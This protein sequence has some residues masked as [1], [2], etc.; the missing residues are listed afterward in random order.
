[1]N[2]SSGYIALVL[3][4]AVALPLPAQTKKTFPDLANEFVYTTLAFSPAAATQNGLHQMNTARGTINLDQMLDDFS[5]GSLREQ[6][7]Y[8]QGF[9]A[10]LKA[11]PKA[12]MDAQTR[13]DLELLQNASSFALFS[14]DKERY[15]SWRPQLYPENLGNSLFSNLSLEYADTATRARDLTIR[16]EGVPRFVDDAVGNLTASNAIYRGVALESIDGVVDLIK[17]MGADFVKGTPSQ[18]RYAEAQSHAIAALAKL[19]A[20]IRNDLPSKPQKD[21]RIGK[22]LFAEK[23]KYYLQISESPAKMLKA[24]E[25][26]M[27]TTR[28]EMLRL[29]TPLHAQWFPGH[30]HTALN[31]RDRLN[32]VV[33]EVLARIGSEH[34]HRDSLVE[35]AT[36]DAVMLQKFVVKNKIMSVTDFSNLKVIPT[37]LFMR[38]IY[39]VAGAVFAPALQPEL[40]TFYWVTP[41]SKEWAAERAESK[42]REYNK[43]KMLTLTIHEAIPGHTVQ[44]YYANL[45]TPDWRRLLRAVFGNTPYIEGWAVYAEHVMEDM[46]MNGGDP[47]KARLTNLKGMLRI[48]TNAIIDIRLQTMGMPGDSAVAMMINEAFQERPEAEAK[49]Q[50]AQLDY[51]QLN[52]YFAGVSEWTKLRADAERREGKKFNQ[53]RYHD[54]VLLY[55]PVPVPTVRSLYFAGVKPMAK[56]P[57]SRCN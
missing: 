25:D 51:V 14:L 35:Q 10:R 28:R 52:S 32:A 8:Y 18:A 55:G 11:L 6:R 53:C 40:S 56:A 29:A 15:Y 49:L 54:T 31:S 38:G 37:P 3:I 36:S 34:T 2:R 57:V 12:G 4:T 5:P 42:L 1:M 19:S 13:A 26:S 24:A 27:R 45:I 43:Y 46:G 39:G 21:W 9:I 44:G 16:L 7:A 30:N 23:W 47:V 17:G 22:T 50:R 41:I 48:Y 20:Y 33:S